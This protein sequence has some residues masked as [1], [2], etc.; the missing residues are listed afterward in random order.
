M[1]TSK[2]FVA[3][4]WL[5]HALATG[6]ALA[7]PESQRLMDEGMAALR[8]ADYQGAL[9][10]F[11]AAE[12]AD[13]AELAAVFF[14]GVASNRLGR[15]PAGHEALSRAQARGL[16]NSEIDFELGWSAMGTA[17]HVQC[18]ELLERFDKSTPGRGQTSEF[19]GRC[20]LALGQ[21]DKAEAL[22]REAVKRDAR[23]QPTVDLSLAVLEQARGRTAAARTQLQAAAA[24]EAPTGR[25]LREMAP[26]ETLAA[27]QKPLRLSASFSVGYNDNVIGLGSTV[28]LPSDISRKAAAFYRL[29]AGAAYALSLGQAS[30]ALVGYALLLDRYD[31]LAGSNLNDHFVYGDVFHQVGSRVGASLRLSGEYTELGGARFR[32]VLA[33]RP[34]LSY[35]F[36]A[37]AV[38]ELS[39]TA[40]KSDYFFSVPAVFDRD[41]HAG[42]LALVH[43]FR[44]RSTPWSGAAGV[45]HTRNRTEGSDFSADA[46]GFSGSLRYAFANRVLA[47]LGAAYSRDAFRNPNSLAGA[48]FAFAREDKQRSLS[49]QLTGPLTGVTRWFAQAQTVRNRSNIA[50]YDYKQSVF[51]AGVAAD[52]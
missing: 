30:Q 37:N 27:P 48:G 21:H 33:A 49:A 12:R 51:T 6:V 17:R 4:V 43:S 25:V 46:L 47:A 40:A 3:S 38:S 32:E 45:T 24:A 7:S 44:V 15:F 19:L 39:Y 31:G 13:P 8:G 22:F 28:P 35:R 41:G 42:V 23:L 36:S 5:V 50:F 18:V 20:Y 34:A 2:R 9:A 29:G 52:F 11:E 10:R 26:R 16:R 1:A 14:Q